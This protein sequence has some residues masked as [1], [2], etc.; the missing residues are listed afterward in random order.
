M[1]QKLPK[2]LK[3]SFERSQ[4]KAILR[5]LLGAN[6]KNLIDYDGYSPPRCFSVSFYTRLDKSAS[7][8]PLKLQNARIRKAS[9]AFSHAFYFVACIHTLPFIG[10]TQESTLI[11]DGQRALH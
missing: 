6:L 11:R 4:Q 7:H 3:L 10:T 1:L 2:Q 9:L 5:K 8:Y